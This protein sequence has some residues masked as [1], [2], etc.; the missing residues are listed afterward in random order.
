MKGSCALA[1]L[2]GA[3]VA[4]F[5]ALATGQQA[6]TAPG[7]VAEAVRVHVVNVEVS[8]TGKDGRP[9]HGLKPED[10]E[11]LEDGK[12]VPLTNFLAPVPQERLTVAPP[13]APAP[14]ERA[15]V[16]DEEHQRT[17]I[18]FIDD[19]NLTLQSRK[20][21]LD[22]LDAFLSGRLGEGY[23]VLLLSFNRSLRQLTPL[24][25]DPKVVAAALAELK[26]TANEGTMARA[27]RDRI[28]RDMGRP[29][30]QEWG[31]AGQL[32]REEILDSTRS[33]AVEQA[34]LQR[35]L[36]GALTT[37]A[38]S[39]SGMPGRKVVLFVS[40]GIPFDPN[41]DLFVEFGERFLG[42]Q[43]QSLVRPEDRL[44]SFVRDVT[45]RANA[46]RI[47]FYTINAGSEGGFGSSAEVQA[48]NA[49][50]LATN[51]LLNRD[52]SL[53]ELT[54]GTGGLKLLNPEA[55]ETMA[56]DLETYY[57]LGY[58]PEHY[59]DG[60]YHAL[61]VR[62]KQAGV[63]ARYREGYL[64][65]T[66]E[67]R[68]ADRTTAA[69]LAGGNDNPLG[70]RVGLGAPHREGRKKISVPLT[71]HIP[72]RVLVLLDNGENREGKV[73]ITIAVAKKNGSSSKVHHEVFPIKVPSRHLPAF[74]AQDATFT[75]TLLVEPGDTSV[76][77]TARDE[78]GQIESVVVTDLAKTL[79]QS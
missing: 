13:A 20:P 37:L 60:K 39:L 65:K 48:P 69:L 47:T 77:V 43:G 79:E 46:S 17:L 56:A 68:R 41:A 2:L 8:V 64:D 24:T 42:G 45:L 15:A 33:L 50:P 40:Q 23:R 25:G 38:D 3:V 49:S 63:T 7:P 73:S 27:Q 55:L 10:F 6:P 76:S 36:L 62:V 32:A 14:A 5:A 66:E 61:K 75:F 70:A 12:V 74:L 58:S 30:A 54:T 29:M 53:S 21:V 51:D 9:V 34:V 19:L 35:S 57:S 4:G 31:D 26:H 22:R 71:L 78:T 11:L 67:Q 16:P 52:L 1:V 44:M 59:G 72:A 18:V 28:V